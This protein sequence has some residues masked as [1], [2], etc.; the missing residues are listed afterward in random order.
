MN[1]KDMSPLW[2]DVALACIRNGRFDMATHCA[3]KLVDDY[4]NRFAP[5]ADERVRVKM[6]C[7]M[8]YAEAER[9][10][11]AEKDAAQSVESV[12]PT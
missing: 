8:A 10:Y 6:E 7:M 3:D 9:E 5:D 1:F 11:R 12:E 2:V 4:L